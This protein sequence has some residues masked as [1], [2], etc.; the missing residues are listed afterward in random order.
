[1][2]H[3]GPSPWLSR[4]P[5]S[6]PPIFS[7]DFE[8][9]TLSV[10]NEFCAGQPSCAPWNVGNAPDAGDSII[11]STEQSF[12]GSYSAKAQIDTVGSPAASVWTNFTGQTLLYAR[13]Y[14]YLPDGFSTSDRLTVMEFIH[15]TGSWTNIL[16]TTIDEDM[17]LY[18]WNAVGGEAYGYGTGSQITTGEWNTL[19]M[20]AS[21]TTG[22][23]KLWLNNTLE[24][25]AT[26]SLGSDPI[27]R[28][29]TGIFWANPKNESHYLYI[30]DVY[31]YNTS[32]VPEPATLLLIG[33]GLVGMGAAA[34]RRRRRK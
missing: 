2:L 19:E 20:M 8:T 32:P 6:G 28:F 15:D 16:S 33:S 10:S 12:T 14:I 25:E 30:D 18:M 26:G 22:E 11:A 7:D 3:L 27:N 13:I 9:G 17:T 29:A 31:V 34:R 5:R 4:R 21:L 24:I 23:A 1:M